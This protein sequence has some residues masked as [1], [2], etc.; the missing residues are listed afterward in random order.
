MAAEIDGRKLNTLQCVR[1]DCSKSFI[2]DKPT[3]QKRAKEGK[4]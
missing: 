2:R 1:V 4:E 3:Q